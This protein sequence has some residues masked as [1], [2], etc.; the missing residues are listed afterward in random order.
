MYLAIGIRADDAHQIPDVL[1]IHAEQVIVCGVIGLFDLN[2]PLALAG[3]S[4]LEKL[5][6]CRRING[7]THTVPYLFGRGCGRGY[8][9][10]G[11]YPSFGCFFSE[12][13]FR[14]RATA[15]VAVTNE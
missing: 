9:K 3:N 12:Y 8:R 6:L 15:D 4:V 7:V 10:E 1:S 13:E 14:H 11:G 2:R 5:S